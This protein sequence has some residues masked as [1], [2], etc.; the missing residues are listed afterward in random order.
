MN[1]GAFA[2]IDYN[3]AKAFVTDKWNGLRLTQHELN[4]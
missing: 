3:D 2:V 4:E 1:T